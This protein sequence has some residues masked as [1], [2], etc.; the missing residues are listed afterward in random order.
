MPYTDIVIVVYHVKYIRHPVRALTLGRIVVARR[1]AMRFQPVVHTVVS[2]AHLSAAHVSHLQ[3]Q[4]VQRIIHASNRAQR[5][6]VCGRIGEP[7]MPTSRPISGL[8]LCE[9]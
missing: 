2:A 9:H 6:F 5:H 8:I 7:G 4:I 3:T 1:V